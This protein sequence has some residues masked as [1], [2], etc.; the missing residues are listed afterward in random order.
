MEIAVHTGLFAK[1]DMQVDTCRFFTWFWDWGNGL[2]HCCKGRTLATKAYLIIN[3]HVLILSTDTN[4]LTKKCYFYN[5]AIIF[6]RH[7]DEVFCMRVVK[8]L[9]RRKVLIIGLLA[10]MF[11]ENAQNKAYIAHHKFM[12]TILSQTYRIP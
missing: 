1:R 3:C 9:L 4:Y 10:I 8:K 7:P 6:V 2:L 11:S 12:A 5:P